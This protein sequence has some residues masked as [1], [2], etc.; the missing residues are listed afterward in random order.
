MAKCI[1]L[2]RVSTDR[3][4][5]ES[6]RKDLVN[7]AKADGYSKDEMIFIE[8]VGASAIKLNDLYLKEIEQL[9]TTVENDKTIKAV[10]AWEISRIGRTEEMLI[11]VKNF[12]IE[13]N[14]NLIIHTPSLRLLNADGTVNNGVELAF[15]LFATMA[16][17]EMQVK[18]QRLIRG[19][20]KLQSEGKF[21]TGGYIT[22]GYSIDAKGYIIPHPQN[23][24]IV[25]EI[26]DLYA[27]KGMSAR[28]IYSKLTDEGKIERVKTDYTPNQIAKITHILKNRAYI[29]EAANYNGKNDKK[30]LKIE[31]LNIYPQIVPKELW[32]AANA[33][34]LTKRKP[35]KT[36]N[37]Y[38]GKG[39]TKYNGL[40]MKV[41]LSKAVY[42]D[43]YT[44]WG[45]NINVVDSAIWYCAI[46]FFAGRFVANQKK[47]MAEIE[48]SKENL[49]TK[50]NAREN[51]LKELDKKRQKVIDLYINGVLTKGQFE[52]K[53]KV[54]EQ[55]LKDCKNEI[56]RCKSVLNQLN[57][58]KPIFDE[59]ETSSTRRRNKRKELLKI[60][61][62]AERMKIINK[63]ITKVTVWQKNNVKYIKVQGYTP[64]LKHLFVNQFGKGKKP[65]LF[66]WHPEVKE[67]REL[68]IEMRYTQQG[69][70]KEK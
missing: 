29:G 59:V 58:I 27:N 30:G 34:L 38:Y 65:R 68:F 62:D 61:D 63:V 37:I 12:L 69:K 41:N 26:F 3:Q 19:K 6:Q 23:A 36:Q 24:Q 43:A 7:L 56:N 15:S 18:K 28:E 32:E 14:V 22:F 45:I 35:H 4:E 60:I 40:S 25:N 52:A 42:E 20:R 66:V 13:H 46:E 67:W 64:T 33:L 44:H 47:Q 31:S 5:I 70:K 1:I 8:G 51:D 39:I 9:K 17:Q 11:S 49:N 2:L 50:I 48:Q 57:N 21:A 54:F 16:K 10:Y 55:D 53:N